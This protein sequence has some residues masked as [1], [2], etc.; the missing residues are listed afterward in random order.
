MGAAKY[1][2]L[3][4]NLRISLNSVVTTATLTFTTALG[5]LSKKAMQKYGCKNKGDG[6]VKIARK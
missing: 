1:L 2:G 4:F 3:G 6:V 5:K